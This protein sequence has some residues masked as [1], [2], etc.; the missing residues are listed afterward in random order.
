M[1]YLIRGRLPL[2]VKNSTR[3]SREGQRIRFGGGVWS[4]DS[5]SLRGDVI[6]TLEIL[7]VLKALWE[8]FPH[9][10]RGSQIIE[11]NIEL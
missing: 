2:S 8:C 11:I 7:S 6:S 9:K 10:V 5:N 4:P 3:I 1:L